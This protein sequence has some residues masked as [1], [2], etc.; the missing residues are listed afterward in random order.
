MRKAGGEIGDLFLKNTPRIFYLD[1]SGGGL[2]ADVIGIKIE[3]D[4]HVP[5]VIIL[6]AVLWLRFVS[7]KEK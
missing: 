4:S 2:A 7:N 3:I 5:G 1:S 6:L